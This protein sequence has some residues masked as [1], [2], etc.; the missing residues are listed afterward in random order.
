MPSPLLIDPALFDP[1][2]VP[3]E[4]LASNAEIV[5]R[6]DAEPEGLSM[7]EVRARRAQGFGAFPLAPKSPRAGTI[8]IEGPGG[9]L[10]LR[11]IA[12]EKPRGVYLHIHGGGWCIGTADQQDPRLERHAE[13]TGLAQ[14]SVEYRLAPEH[15]YPAGPDDCEA[16]ALWLVRE[17]EARFGTSRFAIGG[18]SAGAHLAVVTLLRLRDRHGLTP[19]SA[20]NL[21]YGCFDLGLTPSARRF[22]PEKLVLPTP[23]I[24]AFCANFL[25]N[26]GDR[27]DPDVSPLYADVSGLCPAIFLVGTRDAL[28]DDTLFMAPRW[29]A[30]GN[31]AELFIYPGA[32]HGFV[33]LATRQCNDALTRI[34]TF[35]NKSV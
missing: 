9:P 7:P 13:R 22:G 20:A 4:T 31:A 35:L 14:V 2:A 24:E 3:A 11:V 30:A 12:P 32:P 23:N 15:P 25:R 5:R 19:F 1:A 33:S 34:E 17:A 16:A 26:G 8:T 6:L 28:I 18:E 29:L 10:A 27:N 21:T